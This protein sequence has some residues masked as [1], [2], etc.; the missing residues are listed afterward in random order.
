MIDCAVYKSY[1]D[2]YIYISYSDLCSLKVFAFTARAGKKELG[3]ETNLEKASFVLTLN[4]VSLYNDVRAFVLFQLINDCISVE[5]IGLCY[6]E[7]G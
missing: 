4:H 3:V 7:S 5:D 2:I 1:S 6:E